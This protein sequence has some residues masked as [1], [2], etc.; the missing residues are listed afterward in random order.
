MSINKTCWLSG[1]YEALLCHHNGLIVH[2][3]QA[4]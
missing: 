3:Q 1:Q 4:R 2:G